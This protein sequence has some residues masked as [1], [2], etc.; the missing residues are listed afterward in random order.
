M[1]FVSRRQNNHFVGLVSDKVEYLE[2]I[3]CSLE[4]I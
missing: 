4:Q 1:G 3:V 2:N